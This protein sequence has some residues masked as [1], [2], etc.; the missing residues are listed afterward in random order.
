M[1][2]K[3]EINYELKSPPQTSWGFL[4]SRRVLYCS[5]RLHEEND[6]LY[7]DLRNS[8]LIDCIKRLL[9]YNVFRYTT[10]ETRSH[11]QEMFAGYQGNLRGCSTWQ[12]CGDPIRDIA[13]SNLTSHKEIDLLCFFTLRTKYDSPE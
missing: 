7:F 11:Y 5:D 12:L 4:I 1:R 2:C 10:P 8:L 3:E 13:I 6:V 9:F